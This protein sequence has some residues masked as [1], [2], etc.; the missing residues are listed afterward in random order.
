MH[1][2][3]FVFGVLVDGNEHTSAKDPRSMELSAQVRTNA[4]RVQLADQHAEIHGVSYEPRAKISTLSAR[5][6]GLPSS[7]DT[8]PGVGISS[9]P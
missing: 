3:I 7:G 4:Q 5:I 1:I 2:A 9:P 8:S 6:F